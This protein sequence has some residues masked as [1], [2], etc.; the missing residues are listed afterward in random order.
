MP[1]GQQRRSTPRKGLVRTGARSRLPMPQSAPYLEVAPD[2]A[3][4][5]ILRGRIAFA[6]E[7]RRAH[8]AFDPA[9][10]AVEFPR[11][12]APHFL[13]AVAELP[14][15][16]LV[17]YR[18]PGGRALYLVPDPGDGAVEACRLALERGQAI[19][20]LDELEGESTS[21]PTELPDAETVSTL[22]LE[23]FAA[24][25][26]EAL[27]P[28][29]QGPREEQIARRLLLLRERHERTL[30]V[31]SFPTAKTLVRMLSD[32]V[33]PGAMEVQEAPGEVARV[34]VDPV[35]LGLVVGEMPDTLQRFE[36]WRADHPRGEPF[37]LAGARTAL[38]KSASRAYERTFGRRLSR[39]EWRTLLQFTRHLAILR[40]SILPGLEELVTAA[41]GC[42]DDDFGFEVLK[43][44][45]AYPPNGTL[46]G[47]VQADSD[48]EGVESEGSGDSSG[49]RSG[50]RH[51]GLELHADFGGTTER[52]EPAYD[53]G[54]RHEVSFSFRRRRLTRDEI[55]AVWERIRQQG[56]FEGSSICSWP[57]EDARIEAFLRHVRVRALE[58][59]GESH[60]RVEEF[61]ASFLDGP[62]IRETIRRWDTRRLYVK[63]EQSPRGRIGP[64]VVVWQD[65]PIGDP[66][67]W[68]TTLYAEHQ[69]ESEISIACSP[70]PGTEIVGPGISRLR[71][72]AMMS[73]YPAR[74]I[75]D[76][77]SEPRFAR[78]WGTVGRALTAGAILLSDAPHVAVVGAAGV[79]ADLRALARSAGVNIIHLPL[80]A[81]SSVALE[82]VR[83]LHILADK[84]IRRFA[85]HYIPK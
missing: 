82:R 44:A 58:R 38:L 2:L 70:L 17:A 39:T 7:V 19:E 71:Y 74:H 56:G 6:N 36:A 21:R 33:K 37:P 81:F 43:Q 53:T 55:D 59:L 8:A 68:L 64:V 83:T 23:L 26:L 47:E 3:L 20:F 5:P 78:M 14:R 28:A 69:N 16:G 32:G 49:G 42:I 48:G 62:D 60:R 22:G 25:C 77:W 66:G 18:T 52:L 4:V 41:K 1:R 73:V 29:P 57:P 10:V 45:T 12:L 40:N 61:S 76:I 75:P 54:R 80:T 27:A 46:P 67:L 24:P 51:L 11:P 30:V 34:A 13:E 31:V 15:I 65:R 79:G 85:D 63:R 50:A 72:M 84:G 35:R 9:C